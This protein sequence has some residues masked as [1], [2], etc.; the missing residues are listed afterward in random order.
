MP[1]AVVAP[2]VLAVL[3]VTGAAPGFG[4]FWSAG[5]GAGRARPPRRSLAH[6]GPRGPE[7]G[8]RGE[9]RTAHRP[10]PAG[11]PSRAPGPRLAL[12]GPRGGRDAPGLAGRLAPAGDGGPP[13]GHRRE[14]GS[15]GA[16]GDPAGRG[17]PG[18]LRRRRDALH[19]G[20]PRGPR[21]AVQHR[22][23]A[24]PGVGG[25]PGRRR[26]TP[27]WRWASS[28]SPWTSPSP[29]DREG[30]RAGPA[31]APSWG[32]PHND[33]ALIDIGSVQQ[34]AREGVFPSG[35]VAIVPSAMLRN[36]GTTDVPVVRE[37]QRD[38]RSL[39]QRPAPAAR[40][41]H[42]PDRERRHRADRRLPAEARVHHHQHGL[43]VPDRQH[44]VAELRGHV[45]GG[46]ERLPAGPGA[47]GRDHRPHR[48]LGALPLPLRSRLQPDREPG[49]A[50]RELHG[51]PHG[52]GWRATCSPRA[53]PTTWTPGT[54][55]A[56]T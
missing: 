14:T 34:V 52:G 37:V 49:A 26:A 27:G 36:V 44:P 19:G 43:R 15:G 28:S 35:R 48:H 56:T 4:E 7:R 20:P 2:L 53:P 50:P 6:A 13:A 10:L 39:R 54:S 1:R 41:E 33:V 8:R 22:P 25:A 12:P 38:V 46:D 9:E 21:A 45:R 24:H 11:R 16:D 55:F 18:P 23:P 17:R 29:R 30:S 3:V 32:S 42:V 31:P 51:P 47:E 40:L 5:S